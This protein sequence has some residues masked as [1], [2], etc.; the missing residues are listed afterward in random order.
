ML[1]LFSSMCIY[2]VFHVSFLKKYV[3]DANHVIDWNVIQV[4]KE[5]DIQVH[6]MCIL[7]RKFKLLWI[8]RKGPV[9]LL[10]L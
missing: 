2:N 7:N 4:E 9:D 8:A 5:G 3:H 1:S 10:L 6:P